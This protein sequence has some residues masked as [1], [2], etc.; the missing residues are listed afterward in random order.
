MNEYPFTEWPD[1]WLVDRL[2]HLQESSTI[3]HGAD[4][5][6][7]IGREI[8]HLQFELITRKEDNDQGE[9]AG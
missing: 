2:E 9:M 7:Q 6:R 4:R 3:P 8:L 1:A 5:Q